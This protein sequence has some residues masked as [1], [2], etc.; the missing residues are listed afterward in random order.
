MQLVIFCGANDLQRFLHDEVCNNT[1]YTTAVTDFIHAI[2]QWVEKGLLQSLKQSPYCTLMGD[3]CKDV[4]SM[5]ELSLCFRWLKDGKPVEHFL[6]VIQVIHVTRTDA[7][8]ITS[9]IT[10]YLQEKQLMLGVCEEWVLT[11][12]PLFQ[13]TG[14]QARLRMLSPLNFAIFIHC[15]NYMLQLACV[16]AANQVLL[17]KRVYSNLTT[18]WKVFYYS[19]KKAENLKEIQAV[20]NMP[21]LKM[22]KPTDTCWLA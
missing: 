17:V 10:T 7:E 8:T 21:Q 15:R 18:L 13:D 1:K 2:A 4:S 11:V 12:L 20:L 19:P 9:A 6:E 3:V 14:V 16:Q 5:E 22:L